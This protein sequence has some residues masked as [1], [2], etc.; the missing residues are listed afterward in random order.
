MSFNHMMVSKLNTP[1]SD[2]LH[3]HPQSADY[4]WKLD[5]I[6]V[7]Q[8]VYELGT[9]MRRSFGGFRFHAA[10]RDGNRTVQITYTDGVVKLCYSDVH[11][12]IE[13]SDYVVGRIGYGK[14]YALLA[15]HASDKSSTYM[16][17]SRKIENKKFAERRDQYHMSFVSDVKRAT[18]VAL[19]KL[20][21]YSAKEMA[22][23]SI[24]Q[25]REDV[26]AAR[27]KVRG[28]LMGVVSPI[29]STNVLLTELKGLMAQGV[30]FTTPEFIRAAECIV[31]AEQQWE[32]VRDK[33]LH[34]Y[35]IYVRM[36]GDQQWVD[37]LDGLDMQTRI[38]D[39]FQQT[40][41]PVTDLP[42]DIQ[43][44]IAVLSMAT[45]G[46]YMQGVGRR[47]SDKAFWLE[48]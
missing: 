15:K 12:Y 11:V 35:Y 45:I 1:A 38:V 47:V 41:F 24:L 26:S 46:Q 27:G 48:R 21:P 23:L 33:P 7:H 29:Q 3:N 17:H 44:K 18:K 16:I 31:A 43:G 13:G 14:T 34:G 25:F 42:E 36:V 6:P 32:A 19:S 4:P 40:S 28:A 30:R 22:A 39:V 37:V 2:D 8:G 9:E 10:S 5:G 20:T